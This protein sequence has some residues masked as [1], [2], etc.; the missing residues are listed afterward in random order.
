MHE[1][2]WKWNLATGVDHAAQLIACAHAP[3]QLVR[4]WLVHE[5]PRAA[6]MS[7]SAMKCNSSKL[8]DV[9]EGLDAHHL[10]VR[11]VHLDAHEAGLGDEL[12]LLLNVCVLPPDINVTTRQCT[13]EVARQT[14]TA[15]RWTLSGRCG[16]RLEA[17]N[18]T[19]NRNTDK[20]NVLTWLMVGLVQMKSIG[21]STSDE[22]SEPLTTTYSESSIWAYSEPR[23]TVDDE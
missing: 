7:N 4:H 5:V 9:L 3:L 6:A 16:S 8:H 18:T 17:K 19:M 23:L 13:S 22:P 20:I 11:W 21:S 14:R 10:L 12:A 1:L 2:I 15:R